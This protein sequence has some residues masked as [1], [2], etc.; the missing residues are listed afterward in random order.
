MTKGIFIDA[1]TGETIERDLTDTEI[2]ALVEK[3]EDRKNR[4][5]SE[6]KANRRAAFTEEADPLYFAYR[7]GE[8]DEQTWLDKVAEIRAR[9]PYID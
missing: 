7:R 5:N 4:S 6:A 1:V 8:N 2:D 3:P 9:Y